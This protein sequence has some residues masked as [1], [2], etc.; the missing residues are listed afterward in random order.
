MRASTGILSIISVAFVAPAFSK[1][2]TFFFDVSSSGPELYPCDAG[3]WQGDAGQYCHI[4]GSAEACNPETF[5]RDSGIKPGDVVKDYLGNNMVVK[6]DSCSCTGANGGG[7]LMNFMRFRAAKWE[8]G[9]TGEP[10]RFGWSQASTFTSTQ[11]LKDRGVSVSQKV[12]GTNNAK[13]VQQQFKTQLE[14]LSFNFGSE[15]YGSHFYVDMCFKG[16]QLPYWLSNNDPQNATS[17][18]R[19]RAT[20][21]KT[22]PF[23]TGNAG[24]S[25]LDYTSLSKVAAKYELVCDLQGQGTYK[26]DHNGVG[27]TYDADASAKF[28]Q[29]NTDITDTGVSDFSGYSGTQFIA[30]LSHD[31]WVGKLNGD[32]RTAG[33]ISNQSLVTADNLN[34]FDVWPTLNSAKI[35][36]F[37][38][39]RTYFFEDATKN[40]ERTWQRADSRFIIKWNTE[41]AEQQ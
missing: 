13:D 3:M 12:W 4:T 15:L 38:K 39:L 9:A 18:F 22:N 35:P 27:S 24:E 2:T 7:Y 34:L 20:L 6:P 28:N 1:E 21:T 19:S 36:R 10:N 30:P 16:P 26:F 33:I 37:C 17:N 11:P 23:S 25:T 8:G 32:Y 5:G 14:N 29:F 41:E 31:T 40:K